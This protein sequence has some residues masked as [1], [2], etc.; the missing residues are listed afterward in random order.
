MQMAAML[1]YKKK[2]KSCLRHKN[3]QWGA[4]L[5]KMHDWAVMRAFLYMTELEENQA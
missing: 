5:D 1:S 2:K 4:C 3:H